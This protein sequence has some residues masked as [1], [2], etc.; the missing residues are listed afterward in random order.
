LGYSASFASSLRPLR[1]KKPEY[2][3]RKGKTKKGCRLTTLS[4]KK[5]IFSD[6]L[7]LR[8]HV[9]HRVLQLQ[10][11][12]HDAHDEALILVVVSLR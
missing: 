6:A 1:L 10:Q 11:Q 12:R 9:L 2:L 4:F 8:D 3:N 7:L 5:N